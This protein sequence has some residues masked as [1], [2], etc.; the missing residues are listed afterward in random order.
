MAL[1]NENV[2]RVDERS[3]LKPP[4]KYDG[5]ANVVHM[6]KY[7]IAENRLNHPRRCQAKFKRNP[8][9]K[10]WQFAARGERYCKFHGGHIIKARRRNNGGSNVRVDHLPRFYAK[11][12]SGTLAEFVRE[13]LN[14]PAAE[15]LDILE[16]LA[17]FRAHAAEVVSEY[18]MAVA[19]YN[20]LPPGTPAE[21]V[22]K[23]KQ[24]MFACG[25]LMQHA[26]ERVAELTLTA[27]KVRANQAGSV[28]IHD[29][30]DV[31]N[32]WVRILYEN[33]DEE[34]ARRIER[35]VKNVVRVAASK[36][37]GTTLMPGQIEDT[38]R[39]MDNSIPRMPQP[40]TN[41][42]GNGKH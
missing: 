23:A 41:G 29:I 28:S 4:R 22:D 20:M 3:E 38:V 37:E 39:A 21:L 33:T 2:G 40:S 31:S 13:S 11:K 14:A 42:N 18:N 19:I 8:D 26:L 16:E 5:R 27:S 12:L 25:A 17:L 6:A 36:Q 34:T 24:T 15:Q 7:Y 35:A 10:C 30:V 1:S 9:R 32:Q